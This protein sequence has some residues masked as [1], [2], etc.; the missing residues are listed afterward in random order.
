MTTRMHECPKRRDKLVIM[1]E[2]MGVAKHGALKT[3]IMYKANLSFS[4]LT[5][6][7]RL[8]TRTDLLIRTDFEGKHV[9]RATKKGVDFLERHEGIMDLLG[10]N[11]DANDIRLP[12]ESLLNQISRR[13]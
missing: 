5:E 10:E 11:P 4:Q 13:A 12:P 6:Y 9:Y 7:L 3:Q 2:I 1:A 8:L